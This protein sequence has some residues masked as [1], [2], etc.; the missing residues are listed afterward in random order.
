MDA[1]QDIEFLW[2]SWVN[3]KNINSRSLLVQHYQFLVRRIAGKLF[4]NRIDNDVEFEDFL[5]F[6][7]EG[8]I[9]SVDRFQLERGVKFE[10]FASYRIKGSILNSITKMSEKRQQIAVQAKFR[11][12]RLDSLVGDDFYVQGAGFDE[13]IS[14]TI[15]T[16][17]SFILEDTSLVAEDQKISNVSVF[18]DCEIIELHQI[19]KGCLDKLSVKQKFVIQNHYF[20]HFSFDQISTQLNLSKGRVSQLHKEAIKKIRNLL[21]SEKSFEDYY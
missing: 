16:A 2:S 1:K 5:H 7:I 17:I 19:L 9:E 18:D 4:A 8:L 13:L 21:D 11:K 10:T 14:L 3:E 15:G 6:G 20:E 12:E